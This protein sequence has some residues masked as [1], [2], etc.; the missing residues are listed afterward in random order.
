[1]EN[2]I[3]GLGSNAG[4]RADFLDRACRMINSESGRISRVSPVIETESWGF[5]SYPFLNQI[6]VID[7]PLKPLELLDSLQSIERRLG[8]TEKTVYQGGLPVYRDRTIDLDI[9]D[10][11]GLHWNDERLTLPHP[12]IRHRGFILKSLRDLNI[13]INLS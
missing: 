5:R 2:V 3:I 10:Y 9:L 7:T 1:M 6:I 11:N 12:K 8:R 4:N 13:N